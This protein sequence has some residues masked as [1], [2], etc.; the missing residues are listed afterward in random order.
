MGGNKE[1]LAAI[2][3]G[4]LVGTSFQQP[5]EEGR[6]GLRYV[7]AYLVGEKLKRYDPTPVLP[8]TK[9]NAAQFKP[10]F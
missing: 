6:M 4:R 5:Y 7:V 8:V 2:K 10:Q 1:A 3:A 9:E